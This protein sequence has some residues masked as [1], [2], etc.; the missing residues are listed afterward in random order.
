MVIQFSN[1]ELA[2][3]ESFLADSLQFYNA[4][5]QDLTIFR[6]QSFHVHLI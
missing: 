5:Y 3:M 1:R 2:R 6:A 4:S